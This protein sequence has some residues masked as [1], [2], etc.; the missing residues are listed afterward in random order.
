MQLRPVSSA[1]IKRTIHAVVAKQRFNMLRDGVQ[2]F[3][4]LQQPTD[5]P[6]DRPTCLPVPNGSCEA[7]G[8]LGFL[9]IGAHRYALPRFR[10]SASMYIDS[11]QCDLDEYL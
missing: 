7:D 5:R 10:S 9:L 1:W 3:L 11:T 2:R 6:T 4:L 8:L